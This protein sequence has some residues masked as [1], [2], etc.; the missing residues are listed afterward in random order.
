MNNHLAIS[1]IDDALR[2]F[3]HRDLVAGKEVVD[4]LLDIRSLVAAEPSREREVVEVG[5]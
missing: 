5:T 1:Y 4:L 2:R 3:G